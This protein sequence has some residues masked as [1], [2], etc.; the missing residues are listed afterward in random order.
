MSHFH[1]STQ[2]C[3]EA[4]FFP[5]LVMLCLFLLLTSQTMLSRLLR[6][7]LFMLEHVC[8]HKQLHH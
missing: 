1:Q 5:V 4:S 2:R 6:W 8:F 7:Q 3:R